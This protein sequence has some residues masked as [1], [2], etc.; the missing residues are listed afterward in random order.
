[1]GNL[2][3]I[4]KILRF[5]VFI[6]IILAG[7]FTW[8]NFKPHP[9]RAPRSFPE[10]AKKYDL[11]KVLVIYYSAGGNTAEIAQRI[12]TMT[13]GIL[14]EIKTNKQYPSVPMFYAKVFFESKNKQYSEVEIPTFDL[15]DYDIIFIGSPVWMY[16]VSLPVLSFL[17]ERDFDSKIVIPFG[18]QGGNSG[19]FFQRF[20]LETKNAKLAKGIAF[21]KVSGTE[22]A[23][24]DG[25]ISVWLDEVE[26]EI[27]ALNN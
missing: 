14:L 13:N 6:I 12:S 9:Q 22:P 2:N 25:Q 11:G 3:W 7:W 8:S 17:S 4:S 27:A 5:F 10:P 20:A 21:N 26:K 18:T 23:V 16:T 24:L 15:K 19:N 1:M